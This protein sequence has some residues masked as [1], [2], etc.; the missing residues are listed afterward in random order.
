MNRHGHGSRRN[1]Y[2]SRYS[3]GNMNRS[4]YNGRRTLYRS[5]SGAIAGVLQG[6]ANYYEVPVGWLR[7]GAILGTIFSAGILGPILYVI[8][9]VLIKP[10]PAVAFENLSDQEFYDSYTSSRTLAID[11]LKR[12]YDS[13]DRRIR[14]IES[15]VTSSDFQW[16][17][18]MED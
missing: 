17:Q 1:L 15:I 3:G 7:L 6:L 10:E 12:T 11:R 18:K 16:D 5:R 4:G 14:R 9:V 2:R 8:A 13:L